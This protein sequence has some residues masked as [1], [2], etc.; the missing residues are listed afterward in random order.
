MLEALVDLLRCPGCLRSLSLHVFEGDASK[1]SVSAAVLVCHCGAKFPVWRGV[2][3]ML[4]GP[5]RAIA[6]EYLD[7]FADRLRLLSPEFFEEQTRRQY[8]FDTQWAMYEYSQLTWEV[9]LATRVALFYDEYFRTPPGSLDGAL[10]LDAGCG[11]G[12]LTAALAASGTQI[13]GLDYSESVERAEREKERFAGTTA[14]RVHYVQGD[15]QRPPF[16]PETF[17]VVYSDGVLHHTPDTH[18]SF[19]VL[20]QLVKPGGQFFVMLYRR[21]ARLPYRIKMRTVK[22]LQVLLR[23][24]PFEAMK[25]LC[26]IGAGLL[27]ARL[28]LLY[29]FGYRPRPLVPLRLRAVNLF[30]TL[31]PSYYHLHTASEVQEWFASAGFSDSVISCKPPLSNWGFG[32]TAKRTSRPLNKSVASYSPGQVEVFE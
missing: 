11:N 32:V 25:Y 23:P 6:A 8:S 4:L 2:P 15:V 18:A 30:D 17:D 16:A 31:T 20:A 19:N 29:F 14:N 12:T 22:A 5:E 21:D 13:I 1:S 27:L 3:R 24:L 26:F 7:K 9:N 10:V 28:H